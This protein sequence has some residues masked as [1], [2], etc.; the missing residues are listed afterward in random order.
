MDSR[1]IAGLSSTPPTTEHAW[2]VPERLR[3]IQRDPTELRML[4]VDQPIVLLCGQRG[5]DHQQTVFCLSNKLVADLGKLGR[6][7]SLPPIGWQ[8]SGLNSLSRQIVGNVRCSQDEVVW[9]VFGIQMNKI[10]QHG[11]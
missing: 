8:S 11:E 1:G 9:R 10:F 3:R 4:R 6:S 5:G 2:I 7:G